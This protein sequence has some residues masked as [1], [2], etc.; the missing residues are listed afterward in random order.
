MV[1]KYVDGY[2]V[3]SA[4]QEVGQGKL[5][6]SLCQGNSQYHGPDNVRCTKTR[7]AELLHGIQILLNTRHVT[8]F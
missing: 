7:Q 6:K 1:Q 2:G 3:S 8:A 5:L 4:G